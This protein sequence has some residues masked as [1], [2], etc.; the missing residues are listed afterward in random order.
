M[1]LGNSKTINK[2]LILIT[3]F[4]LYRRTPFHLRKQLDKWVDNYIA[5]DI[6]EP[7]KDESTDWASSLVVAPKPRNPSEVH[8][9][10]DY[11]QVQRSH[12]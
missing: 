11:G 1:A 3:K 5:K 8:V 2:R 12:F 6:I 10:G 7:V 9:C 4:P